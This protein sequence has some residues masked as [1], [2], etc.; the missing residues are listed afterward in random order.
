MSITSP[1]SV[2]VD[3]SNPAVAEAA[4]NQMLVAARTPGLELHVLNA[5]T[6]L[7]MRAREWCD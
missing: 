7:R 5:S 2:L 4:T 1:L 3:P 6:V